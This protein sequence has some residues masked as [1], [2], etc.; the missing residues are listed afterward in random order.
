M[1][2][3]HGAV[4]EQCE[5]LRHQ[6]N[7]EFSARRC[8]RGTEGDCRVQL[9]RAVESFPLQRYDEVLSVC[10]CFLIHRLGRTPDEIVN[11]VYIK[12]AR[13]GRLYGNSFENP[14][15]CFGS[16][17]ILDHIDL[18][19]DDNLCIVYNS[20]DEVGEDVYLNIVTLIVLHKVF[21]GIREER[22]MSSE[23]VKR[24]MSKGA[25]LLF[26]ASFMC[27]LWTM[28]YEAV[29]TGSVKLDSAMSF[30]FVIMAASLFYI[31]SLTGF[32]N[33]RRKFD[34]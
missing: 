17:C 30:I 22:D 32:R 23:V 13:M 3:L 34:E 9:T 10:A 21:S 5:R 8:V 11:R 1:E 24:R 4:M 19:I 31:L 26:S 28:F 7:G 18:K 6:L 29:N 25:L 27:A 14:V 15:V 12:T 2:H 20:R 16:G 33:I